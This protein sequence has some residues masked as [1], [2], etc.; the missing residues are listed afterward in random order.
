[1]QVSDLRTGARQGSCRLIHTANC[2]ISFH[3]ECALTMELRS[4]LR[5]T[6]PMGDQL[7]VLPDHLT[8]FYPFAWLYSAWR[9]AR[10]A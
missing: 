10:M 4:G 2:W 6:A 9:A 8:E 1:M 3:S 5:V 7:R